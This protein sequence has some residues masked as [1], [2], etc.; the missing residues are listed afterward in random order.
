MCGGFVWMRGLWMSGVCGDLSG[1]ARLV[2]AAGESWVPEV[3]F[4]CGER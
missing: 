3:C 2:K 4:V 1:L